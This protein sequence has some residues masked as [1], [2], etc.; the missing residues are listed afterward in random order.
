MIIDFSWSIEDWMALIQEFI[1]TI[2]N[3]FK[4]IGI[5]LFTEEETTSPEEETVA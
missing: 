2:V 3:F 1:D 4:K 5:D